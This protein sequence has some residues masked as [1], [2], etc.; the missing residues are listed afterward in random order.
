MP[1]ETSNPAR[2]PN[3]D[4]IDAQLST[5]IFGLFAPTR[6]DIALKMAHL[7]IQTTAR[8]NAQWIAEFYVIMYSLA[9]SIDERKSIKDNIF[10][11]AD[12]ASKRLPD[13]SYSA[14]MYGFVKQRYHKGIPWEQL[15]DEIYIKYQVNQEDGYDI[16]S[17]E[18]YCNG[19][20]AAGINFAA[21][22]VSL[23]YGEGDFKE[24]VKIGT[25]AGWDSDNPTA[26]WGGLIGFILGKEGI[27]KA[28]NRKFA[29]KYHI[30]RTRQNFSN[31][32]IDT[33]SNM[34][35][36]GILIID[37]VVQEQMG[38]SIDFNKNVWYIPKPNEQ[39]IPGT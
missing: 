22:L 12:E 17:R 21:S 38:G 19:C 3:Y 32:G 15:R 36:K 28:F 35:E 33:F 5:E 26:T 30:H 6:P 29:N 18:L 14:K 20:F 13:N 23:F 39:I 16:T 34:A 4:M 8:E 10:W 7:P 2:N 25:L 1:P 31:N 24:T 9:S 27:E 11:M 37:R